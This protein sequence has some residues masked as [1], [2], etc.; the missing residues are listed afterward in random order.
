MS[1]RRVVPLI[2]LGPLLAGCPIPPPDFAGHVP[3]PGRYNVEIL[4]DNWGVPHIHGATNPDVA[5]G[6]AY[7]HCEDDF[8]TM[9]EAI[10]GA[11]GL[12]ATRDRFQGIPFDYMV[13]FLGVWDTVEA[14]YGTALSAEARAICE[15]YAA[16]VNHYAALH[17]DRIS[18]PQAFPVTGKDV[19]AGFVLKTPFFWG[20][21]NTL[22]R[23]ME[24]KEPLPV[25]E[26]KEPVAA[27]DAVKD[28]MTKGEMAGSNAFAV[29]PS[30]SADGHTRLAVNSH[31]P[32]DGPVSWYEAYLRSDEGWNITGGVFVGTPMILHGFN[33][34]LGWA[35]TVNQ[36]DLVDVYLITSNP[37]NPDEYRFD[38]A[39]LPFEKRTVK[40][41]VR[42]WGNLYATVNRTVKS[43]VHGPVLET[44]HGDY[45]VRI[46]GK[47]DVRL[48]DQYLRMN[49]ATD[50]DEFRAA[51]EMRALPSFNVVY[52][53][54]T[55]NIWYLYN[56]NLPVRT[57]GWDYKKV[58]PGDTPETLWSELA[59]LDALPQVLN[60]SSGFVQNCNNDPFFTSA[61]ED[62]PRREDFPAEWGIDTMMTNRALRALELLGADEA[63]TRQA[64]H[65]YKYDWAYS[66]NG[67]LNDLLE[68][69]FAAYPTGDAVVD[70]AI[71][72]VRDWDWQTNPENPATAIAVLTAEPVIRAQM[73]GHT[74]P[75]VL[76]TL[77]D[78]A[79]LMMEKHGRLD[80]PW[81]EINRMHRG[82]EALA[83]GGGPDVLYAVYGNLDRETATLRGWGGEG[84]VALVEWAPDGS[85][86]AR[87]LHH[88]GSAIDDSQSPHHADQA[89]LFQGR[90][91]KPALFE[92][93]DLAPHVRVAY[94]PGEARD[95]RVAASE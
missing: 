35:H 79:H 33:R 43:T 20:L 69:V 59:P 11:K 63:I 70:Q 28:W 2:L 8:K 65:D 62:N 56:A 21:D 44:P 77:K 83:F 9:E 80:V 68:A 89:R 84:Y 29:A 76:E 40:L 38:G 37:D 15:A 73:F 91:T 13:G 41:R 31:Q 4:R 74:P 94:R 24:A 50:I 23:I 88:Y 46:A 27:A 48:V 7:A 66:K 30:R 42:L 25:S 6:L 39:W 19:A 18:L 53:D 45:A 78:R 71:D 54:K 72:L 17:P 87:T 51:L 26:R 60:P 81:G 1:I 22:R 86:S 57:P 64:F 67:P 61:P 14:E 52:A 10:L 90:E 34:D 85:I 16:G 5:Y 47:G 12:M 36:P 93:E 49:W 55:G 32:W 58:L 75:D 3:E 92:R 95:T 82:G